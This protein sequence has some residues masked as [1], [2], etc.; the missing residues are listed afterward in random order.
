MKKYIIG[1]SFLVLA[2]L[3]VASPVASAQT[4]STT[5]ELVAQIQT[6][7]QQVRSLQE[8]ISSLA[9]QQRE[10]VSQ[11]HELRSTLSEGASDEEVELLQELLAT[12]PTLY[13][14]GLVTGYYGPLT[15][16]AVERFQERYGIERVGI[17]GPRTRA[18]INEL[19][20]SGRGLTGDLPPGLARKIAAHDDDDE[21]EDEDE[22]KSNGKG[23]ILCH[24]PPGNPDAARTIRVGVPSAVAHIA[25]GDS[26]GRCGDEDED[27]DDDI[28]N[29]IIRDID[30]DDIAST[31][32]R[33]R[34]ETNVDTIGT[35]FF[36][37]TTPFSTSADSTRSVEDTDSDD[38]HAVVLN[39]LTASTTYS[40]V[41]EVEDDNG[42][43]ATSSVRAFTTLGE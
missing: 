37:T 20:R 22:E 21:D 3:F 40:F 18:K 10:V 39:D 26:I 16:R 5:A 43:S 42:R 41:I 15:K 11:I 36:G 25:H 12:D 7:L 27:E 29:L 4:A 35:V 31:T 24:R 30:V 28:P 2:V 23:I 33:I 17:V 14:E 38:D 32:A 8:Q 1:L 13:P 6:L 9:Q 34:W 19:F